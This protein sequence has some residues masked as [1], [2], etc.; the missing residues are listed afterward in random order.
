MRPQDLIHIATESKKLAEDKFAREIILET[1]KLL[2]SKNIQSSMSLLREITNEVSWFYEF[3]M[4][5][6][7]QDFDN[8]LHYSSYFIKD[9][10]DERDFLSS[11]DYVKALFPQGI[12]NHSEIEIKVYKSF[13]KYLL[14]NYKKYIN[15]EWSILYDHNDFF[16]MVLANSVMKD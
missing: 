11:I 9:I 3:T 1:I 7:L 6:K 14:K 8:A 16:K 12:K 13:E 2:L 15:S 4:R 5:Q 10:E